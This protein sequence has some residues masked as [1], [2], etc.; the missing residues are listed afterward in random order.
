[1]SY[2]LNSIIKAALTAADVPSLLEPRGIAR[3]DS[4]RPD[5]MTT[6]PWRERR[7]LVRGMSRVQTQWL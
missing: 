2:A 7:C 6:V 3:D 4:K 1:M 5:G